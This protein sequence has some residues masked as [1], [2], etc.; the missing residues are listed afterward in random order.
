MKNINKI[1]SLVFVAILTTVTF[2]SCEDEDKAR[3]STTN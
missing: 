1:F 3:F 2:T